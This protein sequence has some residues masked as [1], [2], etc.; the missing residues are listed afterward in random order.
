MKTRPVDQVL[1]LDRDEYLINIQNH[2]SNFISEIISF[3]THIL[4]WDVDKR[5]PGKNNNI[6][7]LFLR[8]ILE[9]G[10]SISILI[11][12]SSIDPSKIILR[13]LIESIFQLEYMISSNEKERALCYIVTKANRDIKFYNKFIASE[14]SSKQLKSHIKKDNSN[15]NFD[16]YLDHPTF[17]N[18]KNSRVKLLQDEELAE[19]QL[20]YLR[21]NKIKKNPNWYTLFNGPKDLEQLANTLL[22]NTRYQIFYRK[23]SENVHGFNLMKGLVECGEGKAQVIQIRDFEDTQSVTSDAVTILIK[24]LNFYVNQRL[25]EKASDFK[26]WYGTIRADYS[27]LINLEFINY[28]K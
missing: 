22:D 14:N 4:I 11:R 19:F 6:P 23:Y 13:T 9:L 7:T 17:I 16:K 12:K 1:P 3:G 5:R 26:S 18:A 2:C 21:T 20:E 15:I 27:D 25:P 8:N 10:D 28:E 24:I